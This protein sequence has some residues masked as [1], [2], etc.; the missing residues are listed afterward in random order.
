MQ[1]GEKWLCSNGNCGAEIVVTESSSL[2]DIESPRCGCGSTMKKPREKPSTRERT[3][4]ADELDAE[5][6]ALK[7]RAGF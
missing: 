6:Q 2:N 4:S 5:V 3:A 7:K 1:Q